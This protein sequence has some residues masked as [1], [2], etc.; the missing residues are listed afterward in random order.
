MQWNTL[1]D[2]TDDTGKTHNIATT[3]NIFTIMPKIFMVS[4]DK[5]SFITVA[6]YLEIGDIKYRLL[7]AAAHAGIQ[8]HGHY[9]AFTRHKDKWYYKMMNVLRKSPFPS[10]VDFILWCIKFWTPCNNSMKP[11]LKWVGGKTQIIDDVLAT[12]PRD[13]ETYHEPFVGGGAVLFA[14]LTSDDI[15]VKRVC[16]SDNNPHLVAFINTSRGNQRSY[17]KWSMNCF[18]RTTKAHQ[19]RRFITSRGNITGRCHRVWRRVPSYYS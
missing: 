10:R 18:V 11:L 15:K 16:A 12:F 1:T 19:R 9:V 6:E 2:Y 7:A 14:V 17:T 3:R 4:F 8:W 5:K 13:I